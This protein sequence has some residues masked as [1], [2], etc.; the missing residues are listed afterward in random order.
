MINEIPTWKD[1]ERILSLARFVLAKRPGYGKRLR[2]KSFLK[3]DVA[4]VDISSSLIRDLVYK[5][6]SIKYL[7]TDAVADYIAKHRLYR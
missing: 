5:K 4:Q 7:T 6:L 2:G 3:I 1:S